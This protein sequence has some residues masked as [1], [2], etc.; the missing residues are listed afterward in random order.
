MNPAGGG[1]MM[2]TYLDRDWTATRLGPRQSWSDS[3]RS[4]LGIL[5]S[6]RFQ[7]TW[8]RDQLPVLNRHRFAEECYFT[9]SYSSISDERGG[10][11]GVLTTIIKTTENV[12]G[13]RRLRTLRAPGGSVALAQS[14][15]PAGQAALQILSTDRADTLFS[16]LY[17]SFRRGWRSSRRGE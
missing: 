14:V 3:L 5:S 2:D 7:T 11:G 10:V 9:W 16:L 1:I 15:G 4:T 13:N 12:L 17:R 6:S 8:S